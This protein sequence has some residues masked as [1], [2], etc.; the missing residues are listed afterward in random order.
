MR[1][2]RL[3]II[4]AGDD[5]NYA[6]ATAGTGG[7]LAGTAATARTA[8]TGQTLA[9]VGASTASNYIDVVSFVMDA[10]HV[11]RFN[12]ATDPV[13]AALAGASGAAANNNVERHVQAEVMAGGRILARSIAVRAMNEIHKEWLSG[14]QVRS[15]SGGL[16]DGSAAV[17]RTD[18]ANSAIIQIGEQAHLEVYGD[19]LQ[20][21]VLLLE[22]AN[23][24]RAYDRVRLDAGGGIAIAKAESLIHNVD[25]V[26]A[27]RIGEN[28][29]LSSVGDIN[30][31]AGSNV[32]IQTRANARTYGG[33]SAAE[34]EARSN[35]VV[36]NNVDIAAGAV[37]FSAGQLYLRAG[38]NSQGV[39][40]DYYITANTD[41]WNKTAFPIETDPEARAYFSQSAEVNIQ[42]GAVLQSV[43]DAYLAAYKGNRTVYGY[44]VGTDHYRQFLEE[45]GQVLEDAL[46]DGDDVSLKIEFYS[47]RDESVATVRVD[48]LIQVGVEN[49]RYLYIGEDGTIDYGIQTDGTSTSEGIEIAVTVEDLRA[50]IMERIQALEDLN[51]ALAGY[52]TELFEAE[53]SAL[54]VERADKQTKI[55]QLIVQR[56]NLDPVR[57]AQE[58][59]TINDL[60]AILNSRIIT[61]DQRLNEL[62][63]LGGPDAQQLMARYGAEKAE[64]EFQLSQLGDRSEVT[65]INITAPIIAR[66]G[67][68][69]VTADSLVGTGQMHAAGDTTIKIE[70]KSP[71][72]LRTN[73]LIIP[74]N[75]GG[76]LYFNRVP[77]TQNAQINVRSFLKGAGFSEIRTSDNTQAQIAVINSYVPTDGC[78]AGSY[79]V[80]STTAQPVLLLDGR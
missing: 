46:G 1:G 34:G 60:I 16:L 73:Q 26:S 30:I 57:D 52:E 42:P 61:I 66:A 64:L 56:A 48:G 71:Y 11:T 70:N 65:V 15:G 28:A 22:A 8:G 68:I 54:E 53:K 78:E 58:I 31:A 14:Y 75:A 50:A 17:S 13:N 35:A 79:R 9:Y 25:H 23:L 76:Q 74:D 40:G 39:I 59:A 41:L 19:R 45:I 55:N 10:N 27:V 29:K 62:E 44:G 5:N 33:A 72:F 6:Q 18:I 12:A 32:D 3:S 80:V 69:Y 21:G 2:G 51:A 37:L 77:V 7:V 38:G 20:P 4:A 24:V 36:V 67:N 49:K 63:V 47:A 43:G